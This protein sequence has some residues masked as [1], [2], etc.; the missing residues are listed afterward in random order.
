MDI[1]CLHK[2]TFS[3]IYL[4]ISALIGFWLENKL[5]FA[6]QVAGDIG[7]FSAMPN[8]MSPVGFSSGS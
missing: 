4:A 3:L 8:E 7:T 6:F 1:V 2:G 5:A